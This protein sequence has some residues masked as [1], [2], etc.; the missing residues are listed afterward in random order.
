MEGC[1][2]LSRSMGLCNMHRIRLRIHGE[3]GEAAP[4]KGNGGSGHVSKTTGYRYLYR[5]SHPNSYKNGQ[6]TEHVVVMAEVLGRPLKKG[7]SVHHRN[8]LRADNRPC[9]LELWSC[10]HPAGQS[11]L[12]M[13]V[14]CEGYIA[15]YGPVRD[16]LLANTL[17]EGE[18]S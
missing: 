14:F 16:D 1:E 7:E 5:P 17:L 4:R 11:V 6:V 9:N 12:E 15:E 3:T 2:R 13:L 8:G 10:A 18:V